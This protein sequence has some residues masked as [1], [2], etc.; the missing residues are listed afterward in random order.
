MN[1][2]EYVA[3]LRRM[4]E[5]LPDEEVDRAVE[6]YA[7]A[8]E[9]RVEAGESEEGAV[10][11]METPA[12]AAER[13]VAEMPLAART[14]VRVSGEGGG[15]ARRAAVTTALVLGSPLWLSLLVAAAAVVA[16]A[17]VV[18]VALLLC[19]W[20]VVGVLLTGAPLGA[21]AL[22][23]ALKGGVGHM[24]P[25]CLGAGMV[26][27]AVGLLALLP[28]MSATRWLAAAI[29]W[30]GRKVASL[31]VPRVEAPAWRRVP[32]SPVWRST[33]AVAGAMAAVGLALALG[34]GAHAG[35]T[36]KPMQPVTVPVQGQLVAWLGDGAADVQTGDPR[37]DDP[38]RP[39]EPASPAQP[40]EAAKPAAPAAA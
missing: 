15:R 13:I 8:I 26:A 27:S 33:R 9:D 32:L 29:A 34:G 7:E 1:K 21:W 25:I 6:F 18:L 22:V 39:S 30:L 37:P 40:S 17:F 35:A 38:A 3:E 36:G 11:S 23:M 20:I 28:A 5:G 4:L 14:A 12:E 16:A 31:F 10:A 2:R 24:A 19:M